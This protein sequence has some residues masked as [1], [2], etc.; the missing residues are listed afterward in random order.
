VFPYADLPVDNG[1]NRKCTVMSEVE[2]FHRWESAIKRAALARM[3]S[4]D[5]C[6]DETYRIESMNADARGQT[7]A[8]I[9]RETP[10]TGNAIAD[11]ALSFL[12]EGLRVAEGWNAQRGWGGDS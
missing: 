9:P 7:A 3:K 5:R 6:L 11:S 10:R 8:L 12:G 4:K 1:G 2:W